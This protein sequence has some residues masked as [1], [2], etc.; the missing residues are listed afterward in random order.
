MTKESKEI[1]SKRK[2]RCSTKNSFL[3]TFT[4]KDFLLFLIKYICIL[5]FFEYVVITLATLSLPLVCLRIR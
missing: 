3:Q 5:S 2:R 4:N 1:S